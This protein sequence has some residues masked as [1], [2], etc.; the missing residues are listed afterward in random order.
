MSKGKERKRAQDKKNARRRSHYASGLG[1][2]HQYK[3]ELRPPLALLPT[4]P[5]SV[6]WTLDDLPEMLLIEAAVSNLGWK[7]APVALHAVCDALDKLL[8]IDSK[9]IVQ[10]TISS[11][12]L[13][14]EERRA[15]ARHALE[16]LGFYDEIMPEAFL[17]AMAL[18]PESPA[19][20]LIEDWT[21]S[22]TID[23]EL[24]ISYLKDAVRRLWYGHGVHATRCRMMPVARMF[25]NGKIKLLADPPHIE[26]FDLFPKYPS[27]LS[28]DEQQLVEAMSRTMFNALRASA[29]GDADKSRWPQYFWHHSFSLS[30]CI[31]MA[32]TFGGAEVSE[33][34][35]RRAVTKLQAAMAGIR[36]EIDRASMQAPLD[37]YEPDRDE[38]LFGLLSRQYRLFSALASDAWLWTVDLGTMFHRAMADTLILLAW[39]VK[40]D[41]P[42]AFRKFKEYSLGKQKLHKLH[43]QELI[44]QGREDL[45]PVEE[46]LGASINEEIFE[47]LLTIDL[48]GN[49]AGMDMH[50][51]AK[52][53]GLDE[54]Y[55][56]VFAPSSS[57]LHAEWTGLKQFHL[58]KCGNPLHRFHRLPRLEG[59]SVVAIDV[60]AAAADVLVQTVTAWASAY[61]GL[62][63]DTALVGFRQSVT[64]VV[65]E[66][67][68]LGTDPGTTT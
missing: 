23:F 2:H 3:K 30:P 60:I 63:L 8:P 1:E 55:N 66:F 39:Y 12:S 65:A 31:Q 7:S 33:D 48:G 13:V 16:E 58:Q 43:V 32:P 6:Q 17:H 9:H 26:D 11:F 46:S 18:Y 27:G 20:W 68:N 64:E 15:E 21:K 38:V 40:Q 54:L 41:D 47:E 59:P 44:D 25:K 34:E 36:K 5:T 52:E 4:K 10:G 45:L 57:A 62:S 61:P 37:I 56:L 49:V 35:L 19:A 50:K 67:K 29:A 53:V 28:E 42:A 51:M 14:P 24:A 22:R